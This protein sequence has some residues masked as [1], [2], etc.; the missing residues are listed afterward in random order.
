MAVAIAKFAVVGITEAVGCQN[1]RMLAVW[2]SGREVFLVVAYQ[3]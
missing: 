3:K 1:Y 2:P